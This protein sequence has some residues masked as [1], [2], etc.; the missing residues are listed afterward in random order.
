MKENEDERSNFLL[1]A[2]IF[3]IFYIFK[4]MS[5]CWSQKNYVYILRYYIQNV[6]EWSE[7]MNE[8]MIELIN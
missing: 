2:S 8:W 3:L 6:W 7:W 1:D 4:K 5:L